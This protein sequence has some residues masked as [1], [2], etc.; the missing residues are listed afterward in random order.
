[1]TKYILLAG[2]LL[3][4]SAC[5]G[6]LKEQVC[7]TLIYQDKGNRIQYF[8]TFNTSQEAIAYAQTLPNNAYFISIQT[9]E[10]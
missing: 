10:Q 4:L 1:M 3:S 5:G 9:C 2:I 7:V 8:H 6:S